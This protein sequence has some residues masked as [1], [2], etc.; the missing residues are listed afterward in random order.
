MH[1]L[2]AKSAP[3]ARHDGQSFRSFAEGDNLKSLC[4]LR[5]KKPHALAMG[6]RDRLRKSPSPAFEMDY[7]LVLKLRSRLVQPRR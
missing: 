4:N 2:P 7:Q 1:A 3:T 5:E 6:Q